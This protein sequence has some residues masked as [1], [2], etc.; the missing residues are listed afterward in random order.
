MQML[1]VMKSEVEPVLID[2]ADWI[3][4]TFAMAAEEQAGKHQQRANSAPL[5]RSFSLVKAQ[6]YTANETAKTLG[7]ADL[8]APLVSGIDNGMED[9]DDGDD[10]LSFSTK[11]SK[12]NASDSGSSLGG[13]L[14]RTQSVP[15]FTFSSDNLTLASSP[16]NYTSYE[17]TASPKAQRGSY[18]FF[19]QRKS[20]QPSVAVPA[21]LKTRAG[22]PS[23]GDKAKSGLSEAELMRR[24]RVEA[25]YGMSDNVADQTRSG[26]PDEEEEDNK[27]RW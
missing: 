10:I 14:P 4:E 21:Y 13:S 24:R 17:T 19:T 11:R 25:V 20:E 9:A 22:S 27:F 23:A 3:D 5:P 16:V 18:A 8:G 12:I 6:K 26:D 2:I 15:R 7:S 1:S